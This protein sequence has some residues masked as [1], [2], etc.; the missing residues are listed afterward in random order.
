M[1]VVVE[2]MSGIASKSN[3]AQISSGKQYSDCTSNNH[4][5]SA[6]LITIKGLLD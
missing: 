1:L 5:E 2:Q 4:I 6:S 3:L